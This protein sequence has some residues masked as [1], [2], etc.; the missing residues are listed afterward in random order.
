[1][2]LFIRISPRNDFVSLI[3]EALSHTSISIQ[4]VKT[5]TCTCTSTA[6]PCIRYM[7]WCLW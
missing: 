5:G 4:R 1:M 2:S 6:N 3:F 7:Y